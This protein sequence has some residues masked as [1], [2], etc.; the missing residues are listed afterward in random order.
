MHLIYNSHHACSCHAGMTALTAPLGGIAGSLL[1]I[2]ISFF[3][4][5]SEF[6]G[7]E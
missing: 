2:L 1:F 5:L 6:P 4:E 7:K 3:E